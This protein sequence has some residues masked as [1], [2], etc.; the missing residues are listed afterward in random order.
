MVTTISRTIAP[1][2]RARFDFASWASLGRNGAPP[3]HPMSTTA[4]AAAGSIGRSR[5]AAMAAAGTTTKFD[6]EQRDDQPEVAQRLGDPRDGQA[7]AHGG[8]AADHEHEHRDLGDDLE[9][10]REHRSLL[11][12]SDGEPRPTASGV[13]HMRSGWKSYPHGS[14]AFFQPFRMCLPW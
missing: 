2:A 8:H 4:V 6:D 5:A 10:L 11:V 14:P 1:T 7:Q 13:T 12:A 3:T 9:R